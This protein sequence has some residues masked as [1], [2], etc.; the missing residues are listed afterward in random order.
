MPKPSHQLRSF[1]SNAFN[2]LAN[3]SPGQKIE[4][5]TACANAVTALKASA[6]EARWER[7]MD[8]AAPNAHRTGGARN[9]DASS[10]R[11]DHGWGAVM[12]RLTG[13]A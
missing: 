6:A 3:L 9:V 2:H 13:G 10:A 7:A 4:L 1:T 5:Q 11:R 8:R 12:R